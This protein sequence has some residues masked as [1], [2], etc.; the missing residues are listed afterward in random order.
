MHKGMKR[1]VCTAL[2]T[3]LMANAY[4]VGPGFYMG[5]MTG[6][7]SS[8]SGNQQAL[9]QSGSPKFTTVS[10]SKKQW[11]VRPFLGNKINQYASGE[12]G[13]AFFSTINY[14]NNNNVDPC[15]STTAR[16]RDIDIVGKGEFPFGASGFDVFG[17]AGVAITYITEGGGL[18]RPTAGTSCGKTS[19]EI[20]YR[21]T[22]TF[23]AGYDLN[24][25]W[26]LDLSWTRILVGTIVGNMNFY[27]LGI[28]YHFVDKYCGQFLCD[29]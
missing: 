22:F 24:Q 19:R 17:K 4:A 21:P 29:D 20:R 2:A 27:A 5:M 8:T 14:K 6:P 16:V 26:V 25:N 10:P 23:G 18:T 3:G 1:I 9:T 15:G 28:S 12:I 13:F 7:A 11:G